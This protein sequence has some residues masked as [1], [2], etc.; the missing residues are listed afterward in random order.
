MA[1]LTQLPSTDNLTVANAATLA[2][3]II[4]NSNLEVHS[5]STRMSVLHK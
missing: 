4:I 5:G 3:L 2:L 1:S